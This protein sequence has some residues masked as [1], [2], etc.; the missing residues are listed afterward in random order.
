MYTVHLFPFATIKFL[1][2][3]TDGGAVAKEAKPHA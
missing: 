1:S 3:A 2:V